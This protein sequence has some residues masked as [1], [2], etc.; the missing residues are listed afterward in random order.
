MG[1]PSCM[2]S[3]RQESAVMIKV[4]HLPKGKRHPRPI[5]HA[6]VLEHHQGPDSPSKTRRGSASKNTASCWSRNYESSGAEIYL[7]DQSE[8]HCLCNGLETCFGCLAL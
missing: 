1:V 7:E 2:H 5:S 6:T 4:V 8:P 3:E